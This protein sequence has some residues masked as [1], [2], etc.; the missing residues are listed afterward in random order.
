MKAPPAKLG[1]RQVAPVIMQ[2]SLVQAH[3]QAQRLA[4]DAEAARIKTVAGAGV[5][6][7]LCSGGWSAG[8]RAF[9]LA[10]RKQR[11]P[12]GNFG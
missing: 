10:A 7:A 9:G 11:V 4:D 8:V 6:G 3:K 2:T 12:V 1:G 5:I